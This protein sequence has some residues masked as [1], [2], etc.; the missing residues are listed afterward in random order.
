MIAQYYLTRGDAWNGFN[1]SPNIL[2]NTSGEFGRTER[3]SQVKM[4]RHLTIYHLHLV[5]QAELAKRTANLGIADRSG[6]S[7]HRININ[8]SRHRVG[9]PAIPV[10]WATF[11]YSRLRWAI[12]SFSTSLSLL[13]TLMP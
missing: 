8:L 13:S 9:V 1:T 2:A 6:C 10:S 5:E 7:S 4:H 12:S 3:A 11:A